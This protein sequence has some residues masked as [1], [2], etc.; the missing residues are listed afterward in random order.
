MSFD[1]MVFQKKCF[2]QHPKKVKSDAK[3]S[4][5]SFHT[6]GV[7]DNLKVAEKKIFMA[8]LFGLIGSKTKCT[9]GR[10]SLMFCTTTFTLLSNMIICWKEF[11]QNEPNPIK[12][13]SAFQAFT[14]GSWFWGSSTQAPYFQ[15]L[16]WPT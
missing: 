6:L 16:F 12:G 8:S 7:A 11:L 9:L 4:K 13:C 5:S 10:L 2:L 1:C 15:G 14:A 3:W